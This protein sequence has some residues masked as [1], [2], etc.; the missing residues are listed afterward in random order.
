MVTNKQTLAVIETFLE[1][2]SWA[3]ECEIR[4]TRQLY[5]PS[6][7]VIQSPVSIY[8]PCHWREY[9]YWKT[10]C[11]NYYNWAFQSRPIL[12]IYGNPP[13]KEAERMWRDSLKIDGY[14]GTK[15]VPLILHFL[16]VEVELHL[17]DLFMQAT[18]GVNWGKTIEN[19][20]QGNKRMIMDWD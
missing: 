9:D 12:L 20:L 13:R 8:F 10:Q 1:S 15:C 5:Q 19:L 4:K 7:T 17:S 11:W 18:D 14:A 2:V 3:D 6:V 16:D